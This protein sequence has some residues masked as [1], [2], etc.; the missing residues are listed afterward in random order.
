VLFNKGLDADV[1]VTPEDVQRALH[2]FFVCHFMCTRTGAYHVYVR[3]NAD[4]L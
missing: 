1:A 4:F 2:K 3:N